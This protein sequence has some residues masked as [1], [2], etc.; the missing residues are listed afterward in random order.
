MLQQR[1]SPPREWPHQVGL[2]DVKID[3][4]EVLPRRVRNLLGPRTSSASTPSSGVVGLE[5]NL[6]L[7][8]IFSTTPHSM[9]SSPTEQMCLGRLCSLEAQPLRVKLLI[10]P[11]SR[12]V[13]TI[14][15]ATLVEVTVLSTS[16]S[17][18]TSATTPSRTGPT[19]MLKT[20]RSAIVPTATVNGEKPTL[21][22]AK[23]GTLLAKAANIIN[24]R[25]IGVKNLSQEQLVDSKWNQLVLGDVL[26]PNGSV[27]DDVGSLG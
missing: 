9:T 20:S 13:A 4:A 21:N 1:L 18:V 8:Q 12:G 22:Y 15:K 23:L 17:P 25:P 26:D 19:I 14:T 11:P 3:L 27:V 10:E 6:R 7:F 5:P 2:A 16:S 24:D